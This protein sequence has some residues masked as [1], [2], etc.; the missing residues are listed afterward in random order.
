MI[1]TKGIWSEREKLI[2]PDAMAPPLRWLLSRA[3][4]A[5][6]GRRFQAGLWDATLPPEQAAEK[7]GAPAAWPQ[8]GLQAIRPDRP[9]W[10]G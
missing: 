4:A 2:Q 10:Q 3:S 6:N 8:L 7:A 1:P 5:A 9:R